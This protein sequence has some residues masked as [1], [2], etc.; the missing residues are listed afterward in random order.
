MQRAEV[1]EN[2]RVLFV[3]SKEITWRT[4]RERRGLLGLT[5]TLVG[6]QQWSLPPSP[7]W[8]VHG[9]A[10]QIL[11]Q[12]RLSQ[13]EVIYRVEKTKQ[14]RAFGGVGSGV[15]VWKENAS[16]FSAIVYSSGS[17]SEAASPLTKMLARL[18]RAH[19]SLPYG[20]HY[21]PRA[22][23]AGEVSWS[24]SLGRGPYSHTTH[25]SIKI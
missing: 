25:T 1:G 17:C 15:A 24:W 21:I 12:P 7:N 5:C 23:G 22:V 10:G 16:C 3:D 2:F 9:P 4:G 14:N 18:P 11:Q 8:P 20:F 19:G 13:N 6:A